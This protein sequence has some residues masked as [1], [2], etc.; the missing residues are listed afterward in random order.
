[1]N[2]NF[3]FN[4]SDVLS[5]YDSLLSKVDEYKV[6]VQKLKNFFKEISD[7][8]SW[9][10]LTVKTSFCNSL[11]SYLNKF[12]K[13]CDNFEIYVNYLK[14]KAEATAQLEREYVGN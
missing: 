8:S 10:D 4:E 3:R 2:G 11:E 12:D 1:M 13:N 9:N 7:S 6:E 5:V 14:E